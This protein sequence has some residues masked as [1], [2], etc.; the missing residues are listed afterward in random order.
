MDSDDNVNRI[1]HLSVSS[2]TIDTITLNQDGTWLALGSAS[3]G[4]ILVWEWE[5]ETYVLK[6][7]GHASSNSVTSLCYNADATTLVTGGT[8]GKIKLW[9]TRTGF[10]YCTFSQHTSSINALQYI[11]S[12]NCVLSASSDGTSSVC[13]LISHLSRE[14][15]RTNIRYRSCV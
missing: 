15:H 4:Q 11:A 12:S 9:Q 13:V 1:H 8:S 2:N 10:C 14:K 6:Q 3:L 5:S 7:Q